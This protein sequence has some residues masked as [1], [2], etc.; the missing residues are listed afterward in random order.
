VVQEFQAE[1][2]F[3]HFQSKLANKGQTKLDGSYVITHYNTDK[4]N[5]AYELGQCQARQEDA[6][7]GTC[8]LFN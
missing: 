1:L 2:S 8:L 5:I 3:D 6:Q 4:D 7:N